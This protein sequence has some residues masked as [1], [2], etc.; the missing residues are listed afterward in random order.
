MTDRTEANRVTAII[1]SPLGSL[2]LTASDG[3]LTGL[4]WTNDAES[5]R[6]NTPVLAEASVELEGYFSKTL[7]DFTIACLPEGDPFERAVWAA[8]CDIPYGVTAT[9][10]DLATIVGKPARAVGGA[11]GRNPIPI[12]IPCHRVVGAGGR[13]VGYSGKGGVETKQWLLQHEG[14]LLL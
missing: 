14:A 12:I 1:G 13:M 10:G 3:A 9:Y 2:M 8:M 6:T 7:R 5:A 4:D 11:C